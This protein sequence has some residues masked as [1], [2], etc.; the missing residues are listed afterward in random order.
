MQ[1]HVV[2]PAESP[3]LDIHELAALAQEAE[4][5]GYDGVWLP[6][7]LLPPGPYGP[8]KYGGVLEPLTAL[9]YLA[10]VT[11][12]VTLGTSV[13]ILP[14]RDP[15]LVARQAATLA[16]ASG[17]R[18][19]LGVGTGWEEYEFDAAGADF[20]TRGART[21]S[22]LRLIRHLHASGGGPYEDAFHSFDERAVFQPVPEHPVP[23]LIGGNSTAAL[24]RTAGVGDWWQG[25]GLGPREFT[26]HRSRLRELSD[27]REI[28]AGA[29]I[30]WDDD[31]RDA[32][33]VREEVEAW[34]AVDADHLA[35]WFGSVDGDGFGRR[36]RALA[37]AVGQSD[38]T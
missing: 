35:V 15:L 33:E 17:G 22:A 5:L 8:E 37:K 10:A 6:D 21:T 36:M 12:R 11:R 26:E 7:H 2:L 20:A 19:V 25:V 38:Q 28:N 3:E 14:L 13:L 30:G 1:L 9:S 16:R 4:Q 32:G 23:F 29:R 18:F 24:R 34:R 31:G 27:G